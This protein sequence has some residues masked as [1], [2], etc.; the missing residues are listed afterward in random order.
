MKGILFL[1]QIIELYQIQMK[2]S[3]KLN[4]FSQFL[5]AFL[6]FRLNFKYFE[7]KYDPQRFCISE[8]TDAENVV[9]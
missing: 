5:P 7:T 4:T 2:L 9:I 3:Q 1:I 6:K 8:N